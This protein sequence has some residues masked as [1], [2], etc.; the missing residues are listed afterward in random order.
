MEVTHGCGTKVQVRLG[1]L[2]P[3]CPNCDQLVVGYT[4]TCEGCGGKF[5]VVIAT[6]KAECPLC[7]LATHVVE[8]ASCHQHDWARDDSTTWTC[9]AC[10]STNPPTPSGAEPTGGTTPATNIASP[11]GTPEAPPDPPAPSATPELRL[12]PPDSLAPSAPSAPEPPMVPPASSAAS[13]PA[14]PTVPKAPS[15]PAPPVTPRP[16]VVPPTVKSVPAAA[17]NK[18]HKKGG[19]GEAGWDVRSLSGS[20]RILVALIALGLAAYYAWP[21]LIVGTVTYAIIRKRDAGSKV[22]WG[23]LAILLVAGLGAEGAWGLF[24]YNHATKGAATATRAQYPFATPDYCQFS[25]PAFDAIKCRDYENSLPDPTTTTTGPP[26]PASP[27]VTLGEATPSLVS[28]AVVPS[29]AV[30]ATDVSNTS[31]NAT[32][33]MPT[34]ASVIQ[35]RTWYEAQM[36]SGKS[37]HNLTWSNSDLRQTNIIGDQWFWCSGPGYDLSLTFAPD[38]SD[39]P[40]VQIRNEQDTSGD[41]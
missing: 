12:A 32:Y 25:G 8:C 39:T 24:L 10:G 33:N 18:Q 15:A 7:G 29:N 20:L 37:F 1:G 36:P 23:L 5:D 34:G 28:P 17:A 40:F 6:K 30:L 22:V 9:D 11:P 26:P 3:R 2:Y 38:G 41:C 19:A 13:A 14:A 4:R 16:S 31:D 35:L 27:N 21:I